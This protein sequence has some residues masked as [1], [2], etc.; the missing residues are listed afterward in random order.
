VITD[1]SK[2]L[3]DLAKEE[4]IRIDN[5]EALFLKQNEANLRLAKAPDRK[6]CVLCASELTGEEF[7]HRKVPFISCK[8]CR[9]IQTK[10]QPPIG[11]PDETD[12]KEPFAK[13]YPP[14][15]R[16]DFED[17]KNR[18]YRPKLDW[19][20]SALERSGHSKNDLIEMNWMEI[21]SGSGGFLSSLQDTG[22]VNFTGFEKE[23]HLLTQAKSVIPEEKVFLSTDS[24]S[25][26]VKLHPCQVICAFFVIEHIE[27]LH[28]LTA[29]L[30]S[31]PLGTLFC[32]SVPM[33]GLSCLLEHMAVNRYARSLDAAIHV[34]TFTDRSIDFFLSSSGMETIAKWQ[35]GQD[36][37][38]LRRLLLPLEEKGEHLRPLS[39]KLASCFDQLQEVLDKAGLC[40]Q[41]HM[42]ARRSHS[43]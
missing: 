16:A 15:S 6:H 11:F 19:I 26:I 27:R 21:G 39:N 25:Q 10:A 37:L 23:K 18:I 35:F 28:E 36:A 38:E 32:F 20:L 9:H 4:S 34:Q 2:S 17:R 13:I 31:V 24:V 43:P 42:I 29:T 1:Y 8:T 12:K 40:D 3:G 30:R 22:I 14:L 7:L 33:F 5:E 41:V